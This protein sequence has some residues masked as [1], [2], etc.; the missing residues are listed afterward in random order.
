MK[1]RRLMQ[2]ARRGPSLPKGSVVRHS[3]IRAQ[4]TLWVNRYTCDPSRGSVYVRCTPKA[5]I[6]R[7]AR[8]S[9]CYPLAGLHD[10][11]RRG[12][13]GAVHVAITKIRRQEG[14]QTRGLANPD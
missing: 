10:R 5:A 8:R 11:A 7:A 13:A 6:R 9:R 3:K 12:D 1:L 4:M 2:N 14:G